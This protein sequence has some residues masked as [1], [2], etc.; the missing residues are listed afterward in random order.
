MTVHSVWSYEYVNICISCWFQRSNV[1]YAARSRSTVSRFHV[2]NRYRYSIFFS[3]NS[4]IMVLLFL[5]VHCF[6]FFYCQTN[7]FCYQNHKCFLRSNLNFTEKNILVRKKKVLSF[8]K[9]TRISLVI[10]IWYFDVWVARMNNR[11]FLVLLCTV[12][13]R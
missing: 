11:R 5:F 8:E 4:L 2:A 1:V 7:Y 6:I 3:V 10:R 9:C 12:D 13:Y